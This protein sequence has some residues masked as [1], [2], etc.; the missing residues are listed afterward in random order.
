MAGAAIDVTIIDTRGREV[1]MGSEVDATPEE[2]DMR[3]YTDAQNISRAARAN[4]EMLR[5]ALS[6]AGFMNYPT[7]WWHW[8]FGDRY[9]ARMTGAP[10]ALY[11]AV[12]LEVP[13]CA[14]A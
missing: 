1:D 9:W 13:E 10:H 4:R 12:R 5:A 2:C 8:S 14:S 11:D 3:C 6:G 7:E